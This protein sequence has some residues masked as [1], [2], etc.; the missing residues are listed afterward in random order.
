MDIKEDQEF[1]GSMLEI[2]VEHRKLSFSGTGSV[3]GV[4]R[5]LL[6]SSSANVSKCVE[7]CYWKTVLDGS[8][9]P[10]GILGALEETRASYAQAL[11]QG[12]SSQRATAI[13]LQ[14]INI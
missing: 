10:V 4:N 8:S 2:A 14:D 11:K 13:R 3:V 9:L 7:I 5:A 1:L 6:R 12:P